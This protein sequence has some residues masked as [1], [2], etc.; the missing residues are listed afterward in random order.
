MKNEFD[1]Q[2]IFNH[3]TRNW[4]SAPKLYLMEPSFTERD[5]EYWIE[6][7]RIV[8]PEY[9][10]PHHLLHELVHSTRRGDRIPRTFELDWLSAPQE[11]YY[12]EEI[13]AYEVSFYACQELGL[14][15]QNRRFQGEETRLAISTIFVNSIPV[16]DIDRSLDFFLKHL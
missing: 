1:L 12:K 7:D 8:I 11:A 13:V 5:A 10:H 16:K 2:D 14:P 3:V 6:L 15:F 4:Y 9:G